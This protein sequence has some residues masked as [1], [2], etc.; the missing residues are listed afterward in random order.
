MI[1]QENK[2]HVYKAE[3]FN[4]IPKRILGTDIECRERKKIIKTE[5]LIPKCLAEIKMCMF[6]TSSALKITAGSLRFNFDRNYRHKRLV[7]Y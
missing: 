3:N 4:R 2:L 6:E 1:C 7:R 5:R